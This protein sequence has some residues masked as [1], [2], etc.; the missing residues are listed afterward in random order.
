VNFRTR[1]REPEQNLRA[2]SLRNADNMAEALLWTELKGRK[3]NGYKFVRQFPIG[4]YFADFLCRERR[5]VVEVDGSQHSDS[6][7]DAR[8]DEYVRA[9]AY[10]VIRFWSTDVIKDREGVLRSIHTALAGELANDVTATDL[11]FIAAR[12]N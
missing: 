8:R 4:P 3:L 2:K 1:K 7:Y 12:S 10:S 9:E 11:R 6:A 5:L